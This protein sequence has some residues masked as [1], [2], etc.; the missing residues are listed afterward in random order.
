MRSLLPDCYSAAKEQLRQQLEEVE[1]CSI[2]TDFWSSCNAQSY[3]TVTCHFLNQFWELKSCVLATCQVKMDHTAENIKTELKRI[4]DEWDITDK[5]SCIVTDSAAN[6]IAA[7]RLTGWRHLPCF[8]HT[9]N[10]IVQEATE[11]DAELAELR[12]KCRSIVTYF[13]QSVKARD[14]LTEV[15]KQMGGEEK[16]LIRDVVTRWNSS[17]YMYE[18]LVE[19]YKAVNTTLCFFDHSQLCLSSPEVSIMSDAVKMLRHFEQAT[20][21]I[22]ADKYLSVS[23]VIPLARSLQCVTAECTSLRALKQ[24]LLSSMAR[25]F[26]NIEMNYTLA[27]STLLDPRFKKV[28]FGNAS[29]CSQTVLRLTSEVASIIASNST[30]ESTTTEADEPSGLWTLIDQS[31]A[32]SQSRPS[33][34]DSLIVLR[35]YL[36]QPN[37]ARKEEPLKWWVANEKSFPSLASHAKKYLSIP[38]T[39]VSSERLFSKAGEITSRKRNR[40]KSKNV[41]MLLFL[42]KVY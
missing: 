26:T 17:Y 8:A 6:M 23:K 3:I 40:I 24:E 9:L 16:K 27:V 28:G 35:M 4:T 37:L 38:A 18:R 12:Q 10:L 33:T 14:K 32:A 30:T 21:E 31:V 34:S 15:Q 7:A 13:K 29:A 11:K 22:S 5:I 41:D 25:R 42:N 20:R 2:T 39:S 19:Q 1:T 36:D